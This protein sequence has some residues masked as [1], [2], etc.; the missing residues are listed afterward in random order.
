MR[1][2]VDK[3]KDALAGAALTE[4]EFKTETFVWE[5]L[6]F[7]LKLVNVPM[8][9]VW[10]EWMMHVNMEVL[11]RTVAFL[12]V[13]TTLQWSGAQ[14]RF[15]LKYLGL[16]QRD[17]SRILFK[18]DSAFSAY[19]T[20]DRIP[21]QGA[22]MMMRLYFISL[23]KVSDPEFKDF[24]KKLLDRKEKFKPCDQQPMAIDFEN[25][26]MVVP[27]KKMGKGE[28]SPDST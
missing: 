21:S 8:R 25:F 17:T 13:H 11:K 18:S 10:G 5:G 28:A 27:Y 14:L 19:C 12:L 4:E 24:F 6:G 26:P 2:R 1:G 23:L 22:E 20:E 7:P 3:G 16:K 15:M 9:N